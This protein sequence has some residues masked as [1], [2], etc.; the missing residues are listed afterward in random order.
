MPNI[1]TIAVF[2][3]YFFVSEYLFWLYLLSA[4]GAA[5]ARRSSVVHALAID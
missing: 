4:Y 5:I 2:G 3:I 1:F